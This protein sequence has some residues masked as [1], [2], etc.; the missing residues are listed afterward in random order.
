MVTGSLNG[1]SSACS[2]VTCQPLSTDFD[3]LICTLVDN[4]ENFDVCPSG[5][6]SNKMKLDYNRSFVMWAPGNTIPSFPFLVAQAS[7]VSQA[8]NIILVSD[9]I[10][11]MISPFWYM[12]LFYCS[13]PAPASLN[14]D[15]EVT[16]DICLQR[17]LD[18]TFK[19]VSFQT[20]YTLVSFGSSSG[21]VRDF[22]GRVSTRTSFSC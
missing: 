6:C 16:R 1:C 11:C 7:C 22:P 13:L 3:S 15:T 10:H 5:A 21:P 14:L 19:T 2:R 20:E 8:G 12:C 17:Q 9:I 18:S 4:N